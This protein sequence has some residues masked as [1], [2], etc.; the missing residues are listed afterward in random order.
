LNHGNL[1][2][3]EWYEKAAAKDNTDAMVNLG[4]LYENGEGMPQDFAKAREWYE[5]AAANGYPEAN[6]YLGSLSIRQ[7]IGAYHR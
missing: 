3:R 1:K 7:I 4:S 6:E 5:K 2:A